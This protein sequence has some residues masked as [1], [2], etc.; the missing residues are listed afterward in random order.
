MDVLKFTK[1]EM[2]IICTSLL[3]TYLGT[4][5]TKEL[6]YLERIMDKAKKIK[7]ESDC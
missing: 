2:I 6:I 7:N 3:S 5:D 1:P 4:T